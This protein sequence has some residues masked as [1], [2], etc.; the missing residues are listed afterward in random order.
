MG[1]ESWRQ[2]EPYETNETTRARVSAEL[3]L[4]PSTFPCAVTELVLSR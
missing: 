4:A 1:E 2:D 3:T